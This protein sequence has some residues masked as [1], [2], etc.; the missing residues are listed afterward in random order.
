MDLTQ[1]N[2]CK[3]RLEAYLKDLLE[4]VGRS[5]RRKWVP[6]MS[7]AFRWMKKENPLSQWQIGCLM[8]I[9]KQ[10]NRSSAKALGRINRS[11]NAWRREFQGK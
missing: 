6:H 9:F 8:A 3:K 4:P 10:C 7:A 2:K 5:E 1:L 11:G